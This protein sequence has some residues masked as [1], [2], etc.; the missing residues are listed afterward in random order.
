MA[1]K[2]S[3]M[4]TKNAKHPLE[5]VKK[6]LNWST[7]RTKTTLLIPLDM[8]N[9]RSLEPYAQWFL[10]YARRAIMSC[11]NSESHHLKQRRV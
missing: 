10:R 2:R 4:V 11:I 7:F 1:S 5:F 8:R 6:G 9:M 3:K